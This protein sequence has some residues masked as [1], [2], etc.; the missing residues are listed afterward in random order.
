VEYQVLHV[1]NNRSIPTVRNFSS[2]SQAKKYFKS[3]KSKYKVLIKQ[4][5]NDGHYY[6]EIVED[7]TNDRH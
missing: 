3:L 7:K 6:G 5:Y 4:H 1:P 2:E